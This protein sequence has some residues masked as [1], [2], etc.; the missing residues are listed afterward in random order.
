MAASHRVTRARR[1]VIR[2]IAIGGILAFEQGS[3]SSCMQ[4][5]KGL[6]V[7]AEILEEY[8]AAEGKYPETFYEAC[9]TTYLPHRT[10]V[11]P[12][13]LWKR[14]LT[15]RRIGDS[16][17]LFSWGPD[18]RSH[19]FDDIYA[20]QGWCFDLS[21]LRVPEAGTPCWRAQQDLLR[22][23]EAIRDYRLA[24]NVFPK[25]L[26]DLDATFLPRADRGDDL[27]VDPWGQRYIYGILPGAIYG[28]LS[29]GP[30]RLEDTAD[31]VLP[32]GPR[33]R[34]RDLPHRS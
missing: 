34:K 7:L 19:T 14:P 18:E 30:D 16:Y 20:G 13:D 21:Q 28:L 10:C 12:M 25:E 6:E 29:S 17:E 23:M 24:K 22:L 8:H 1:V 33:S 32:G 9:R 15:Y 5:L 3:S 31:D 26:G 4:V 27:F 2:I 11:E